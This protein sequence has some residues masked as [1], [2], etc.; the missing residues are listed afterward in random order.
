MRPRILAFLGGGNMGEAMLKGLLNARFAEPQQLL[1]AD[2][3]RQRVEYLERTYGVRGA[4]NNR[5]AVAEAD[6]IILAVKPQN[7]PELLQDIREELDETKLVISI[8]A[9]VPLRTIEEIVKK[10][11]RLIRTMPNTPALVQEA[12][13]ALARG[14]FAS[15]PDLKLAE[16]IFASVGKT[17]VIEENL[18]DAVTGLSG[19]GPAYVF[20]LIE[21]M[22]DS[23]VKM[24][25]TRQASLLLSAQT[26]L[27]AAR[28]LL[29]TNE[30]PGRLKDMVCSPGGTAIV[31]L[32]TLEQG[33]L[34]T[35]IINAVE[36]ATKRSIELGQQYR[37]QPSSD[38]PR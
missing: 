18:M 14:T 19:S 26:V 17:I 1:V 36:A 24:G 25:L 7:L 38:A 32:H 15:E 37:V 31:G 6:V 30:H 21:A 10:E 35:T 2:I 16:Q 3:N 33:G 27:G 29:E 11:L 22:A 23:G 13:T 20:L 34:R 5:E 4:V 12:A 28:L 9:G 8:A